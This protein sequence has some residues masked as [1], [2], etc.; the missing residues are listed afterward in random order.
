MVVELGCEPKSTQSQ[1]PWFLFH[2]TLSQLNV[3][4]VELGSAIHV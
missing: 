3:Q 2:F 1:G 4:P